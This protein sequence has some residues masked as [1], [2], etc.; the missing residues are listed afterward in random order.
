MEIEEIVDKVHSL[1]SAHGTG[2]LAAEELHIENTV[3]TKAVTHY[4]TNYFPDSWKDAFFTEDG[5]DDKEFA[6][7]LTQ[8]MGAMFMVAVEYE[9]D[10]AKS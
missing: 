8:I 5:S 10:K 3:I 9:R 4:V 1:C 2:H 6:T 7:M